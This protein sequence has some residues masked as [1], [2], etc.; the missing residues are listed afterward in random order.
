MPTRTPT[1]RHLPQKLTWTIAD[2]AQIIHR[3]QS[4]R[5]AVAHCTH[6]EPR[7][8]CAVAITAGRT[9]RRLTYR[10][11]GRRPSGTQGATQAPSSSS[12]MTTGT[13]TPRGLT[14]QT[15]QGD[16][17]G[18]LRPRDAGPT[19]CT[20][21]RRCAGAAASRSKTSDATRL[22]Q[23]CEPAAVPFLV[24]HSPIMRRHPLSNSLL[25]VMAPTT[26]AS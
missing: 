1:G 12:G 15:Q 22:A 21:Q 18:P 10:W 2:L 20:L 25:A 17:D 3:A 23:R 6:S 13:P 16:S 8:H 5:A 7:K 19:T 24:R 11:T 9:P 14:T 26:L 4:V